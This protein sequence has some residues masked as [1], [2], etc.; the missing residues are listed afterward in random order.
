MQGVNIDFNGLFSNLQN[1]MSGLPNMA[2]GHHP[3]IQMNFNGNTFTT[4]IPNSNIT[5]TSNNN[6]TSS[7]FQYSNFHQQHHHPQ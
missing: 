2:N 5:F 3:N 1:I 7:T 4:N 6:G